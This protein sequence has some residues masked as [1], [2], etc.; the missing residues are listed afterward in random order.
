V[1]PPNTYLLSCADILIYTEFYLDE[2]VL[3]PYIEL[4][5][6]LT[7]NTGIALV[8]SNGWSSGYLLV[9]TLLNPENTFYNSGT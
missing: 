1:S 6:R 3:P 4:P 8:E 2:N 7:L 5:S 9:G